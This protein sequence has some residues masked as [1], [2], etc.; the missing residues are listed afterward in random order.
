MPNK[1]QKEL[2]QIDQMQQGLT[3]YHRRAAST[4][5]YPKLGGFSQY[6]SSKY[7]TGI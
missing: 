4:P 6:K 1:Y 2:D 7:S 5:L 3:A